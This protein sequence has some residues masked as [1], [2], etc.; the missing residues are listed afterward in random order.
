MKNVSGGVRIKMNMCSGLTAPASQQL[1][2]CI[3]VTKTAGF[4]YVPGMCNSVMFLMCFFV[5]RFVTTVCVS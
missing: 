5:G 1:L 2:H 4:D 3:F